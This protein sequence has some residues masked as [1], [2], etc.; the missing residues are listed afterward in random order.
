MSAIL[1]DVL[2]RRSWRQQ[3]RSERG[4]RVPHRHHP[5]RTKARSK[6]ALAPNP[7]APDP[8]FLEGLPKT[9]AEES[10]RP[11][12]GRLTDDE[13]HEIRSLARRGVPRSVLC[14]LF[15]TSRQNLYAIIHRKTWTLF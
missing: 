8:Q 3:A 2:T 12:H 15:R 4:S 9:K 5:N 14:V 10:R 11:R 6:L 7:F 1:A 13:V